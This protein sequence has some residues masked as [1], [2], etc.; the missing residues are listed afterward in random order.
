MSATFAFADFEVDLEDGR[1]S[2]RGYSVPLQDQ[3]FRLLVLL[4]ERAGSVVTREEIQTH[5][6]PQN[7][8]VEFD[9]SL[10]VA[11]SKLRE[12]LRDSA[13]EPVYIETLPRRG[14]RFIAPVTFLAPELLPESAPAIPENFAPEPVAN[15]PLPITETLVPP[16]ARQVWLLRTILG[17]A[18]AVIIVA[19]PL[20]WMR[21]NIKQVLA[22]SVAAHPVVRPAVA[23]LGL[24]NLT[25]APEDRWLSTAL[26]EMLSTELSAS[27]ALRVIS[28]EEIAR[29]GVANPP[30]NSPSHE[31]LVGYGSRLG[32]DMIVYGSYTVVRDRRSAAPR[33]RL[34]LHLEN[35]GSDAPPV[36]LAQAGQASDLFTLISASGSELRQ[37]FGLGEISAQ[38][39][40]AVRRTLPTNASAA[41]LY[42]EGLERMRNFDPEGARSLFQQATAIEP[43]HA[44]AH[45]ALAD[46][47]HALGYDKEARDEAEKAVNLGT[48]LPR[49]ELLNMQA[50]LAL[51][52]HDQAKAIELYRS[53]LDFYP[54]YL[55][56]GLR[57]AQAQYAYSQAAEGLATLKSLRRE[58]LPRAD[59]A[60]IAIAE[61]GMQL[62]LG[63]FRE[64]IA[65][66]DQALRIGTD[67]DNKLVRAQAL[68]LKA[69]GLE[70]MG[71]SPASLAASA[72]SQDLYRT[73]GDKSGMGI[74]LLMSGDVLYDKGRYDEARKN[75]ESAL[76]LFQ[77]IG[78]RRNIGLTLERIGNVYYELGAL[79]ESRKQYQQALAAY[80]EIRS[81]SG[82]ASAIGNIANVQEAEGDIAGALSSNTEGLALFEKSGVKRGTASTHV[83]MG[84]LE[85]ER[86]SPDAAEHH[87]SRAAEIDRQIG[88]ARGLAY[89]T[90]GLG[91]VLLMRNEIPAALHQYDEAL[92]AIQG[93]DEPEVIA[94]AKLSQGIALIH[95]GNAQQAIGKLK[96]ANEINLRDM[97]HSNAAVTLAS[98]SRA[99]LIQN[100]SSD[101]LTTANEAVA[102]AAK[103]FSPQPRL[104][105]S[106]AFCRVRVAQG[107]AALVRDQI[108]SVVQGAQKYN[109]APLAMESRTLLATTTPSAGER[110]RQLEALAREATGNGWKLLASDAQSSPGA[111]P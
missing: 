6:W 55:D 99:L 82:L 38:N 20:Y 70:R 35:L 53:L 44:G 39:A 14:Y 100:R 52:S 50:E 7:T 105:A 94:T 88:Y 19:I 96:E 77:Q 24:R 18:A 22:P 16:P 107:K 71:N 63:D 93:M 81:D 80:R 97:D 12:A 73:A 65:S 33:L 84:N 60:R 91:D 83:N 51:F 102:E 4:L 17:I 72:E 111:H 66:A 79:A 45:F 23:V 46:A 69:S 9:K 87:Y 67:L 54:G 86:G 103:Q 37:H 32:A 41:Q 13:T 8:Y 56:Y 58:G 43:S 61:A 49:Q 1:L 11:V 27:D 68:W 25:G 3:P 47:W 110:S 98:I 109:Y 2:R 76:A 64:A 26:A 30:A 34:D 10:R 92:K 40:S 36:V 15:V 57:L 29:A 62:Q 104:I 48:G 106:L 85:M 31:T 21:A 28:G 74:V 59:S 89:A 95:S 90:A 42:S 78:H 108:K 75:F 5:L 101:A